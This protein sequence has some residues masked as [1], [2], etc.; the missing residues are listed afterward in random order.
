MVPCFYP[1]TGKWSCN[2]TISMEDMRTVGFYPL[3][4][5]WSCNIDAESAFWHGLERGF[6]SPYGEMII[7]LADEEIPREKMK[8]FLSP[9]GE[10]ILQPLASKMAWILAFLMGLR[11][12]SENQ[13]FLECRIS[14]IAEK[15][16]VYAVRGKTVWHS[17]QKYKFWLLSEIKW[18]I[19]DLFMCWE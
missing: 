6:L 7:Q 12:K 16:S 8:P 9:Y 5:K 10:M 3:T 13:S 15:L 19:A 4:G 1:L 18:I 2:A 14:R 17:V 11:G